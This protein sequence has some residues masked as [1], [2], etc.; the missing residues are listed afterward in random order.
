MSIKK[1][2][3]L[4]LQDKQFNQEELYRITGYHF[5]DVKTVEDLEE[6]KRLINIFY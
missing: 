4:F 3:K 6:V 2:L 5:E 1:Q